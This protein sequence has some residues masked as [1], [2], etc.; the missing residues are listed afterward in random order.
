MRCKRAGFLFVDSY[1]PVSSRIMACGA[2]AK[3]K[4]R[5][6]AVLAKRRAAVIAKREEAIAK[7]AAAQQKIKIQQEA[8]KPTAE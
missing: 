2:C 3:A 5:R 6:K 8:P 7:A 1:C 4:A